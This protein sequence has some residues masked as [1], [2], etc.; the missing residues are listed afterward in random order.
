VVTI[1]PGYVAT[2]MTSGNPYRM[3][4]LMDVD[5]AAA[6]MARAIARRARFTVLPW[7]MA[8]VGSVLRRLPRPIYDA[9]FARAPRKPRHTG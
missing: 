9:A 1:C 7:P 3:P 4:F 2:P 5:R 6:A 8:L